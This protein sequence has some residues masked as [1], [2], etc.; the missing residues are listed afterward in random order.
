MRFLNPTRTAIQPESRR[1]AVV[2]TCDAAGD[3][4]AFEA[5]RFASVVVSPGE[6][7]LFLVSCTV[8]YI[9]KNGVSKQVMRCRQ[10]RS[11]N[12]SGLEAV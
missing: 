6:M 5:V 12:N 2:A 10:G 3:P 11:T 4:R 1:T 7:M 9:S 8:R